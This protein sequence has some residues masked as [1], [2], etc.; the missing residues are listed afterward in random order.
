MGVSG[1]TAPQAYTPK[2]AKG[3]AK[4]LSISGKKSDQAEQ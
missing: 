4:T 2:T 1:A 3:L